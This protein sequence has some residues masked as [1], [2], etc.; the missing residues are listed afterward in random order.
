MIRIVQDLLQCP[1]PD[2]GHAGHAGRPN[3]R[4]FRVP[5]LKFGEALM[6]FML[7]MSNIEKKQKNTLARFTLWERLAFT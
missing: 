7:H 1:A 4:H 3:N 5:G 2:A 6:I